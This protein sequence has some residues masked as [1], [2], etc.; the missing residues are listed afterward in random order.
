MLWNQQSVAFPVKHSRQGIGPPVAIPSFAATVTMDW[1]RLPSA[2][3]LMLTLGFTLGHVAGA[4]DPL[5]DLIQQLGNSSFQKRIDAEQQLLKRGAD[6]LRWAS[7]GVSASDP[8]IRHRSQRVLKSLQKLAFIEHRER[9]RSNPWTVAPELAP[10][11]ETFQEFV[12]D[13]RGAR[14]LYVRMLEHEPELMMALLLKAG[15]WSREFDRRCADLRT[16]YDRRTTQEMDQS[17]VLTLLFIAV[18]PETRLGQLSAGT[19]SAL[20]SEPEFRNA[21]Q[22]A[23]AEEQAVYRALLSRWIQQSGLASPVSRMQLAVQHKLVAG[24]VPAKEIVNNS[25]AVGQSRAQLQQ[26]INFLA[27]YGTPAEIPDLELLLDQERLLALTLDAGWPRTAPAESRPESR[28]TRRAASGDGQQND[29]VINDSALLALIKITRQ[30]PVDYG[31]P[32]A[33]P[34]SENRLISSIPGF[35][36]DADRRKAMAKWMVWRLEHARELAPAQL[37][38]SEGEPG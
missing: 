27:N 21:V 15:D 13:S 8:E 11:W 24:I 36:S 10:A 12:G 6:G 29:L 19:V 16:F 7:V 5:P 28:S 37:D 26:A 20:I 35:T 9:V 32:P 23:P 38:A 1:T 31:Y 3:L 30:N 22:R 33:P 14:D 4:A 18:T 25:K 34:E 17:S 2:G